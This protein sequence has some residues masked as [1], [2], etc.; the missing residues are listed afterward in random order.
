M[1]LISDV[2]VF[3]GCG[4][5]DLPTPQ[6]VAASWHFIKALCG[7]T[8]PGAV[9]PFGKLS[10]CCYSAGYSAGYGHHRINCGGPIR[11]LW[12]GDRFIGI[13]HMHQSGIGAL[14]FY[15]NYAL[16]I[17]FCGTLTAETAVRG[18]RSESAEPGYY[19]VTSSDGIRSEVTVSPRCARHRYTFPASGGR[20]AIDFTNDG[21]YEGENVASRPKSWRVERLSASEAAAEAVL[22]GVCVSFYVSCRGSTGCTLWRGSAL[23]DTDRL[24]ACGAAAEERGGCCFDLAEQTAELVVSV[25]LRGERQAREAAEAETASFET[26]R[27]EAHRAWAE[28]LSR[29]EIETADDREREIFASNFYHSLVKPSDWQD[30]SFLYRQEDFM[31]DFCTLWDQYKTQL[32]LIFTLFDDI[33]GKIVSTYEALSETLGF[34]P[35]TFVLCDQFRI[36]AKQAQMLGVYVLYDAFCRGIG[37]PESLLAAIRRD[38]TRPEYRPFFETGVCEKTT[39]TLDMAEGCLA[40]AEL[41]RACGDTALANHL[42]SSA[43]SVWQAFDP[44][45]GLLRA[46]ADYYEGNHWNYSFRPMR[47]MR[48][49]IALTGSAEAFVRLCDRFFGFTDAADTTARFEGFNNE[50]DM[51]APYAYLYAGRHDRLCDV[52]AD[53]LNSMFT[54]G[55]GGLPGNNDSGGLSSCYLWNALGVF[56]VSGQN[57]MLI[58]TPRF[59]QAVL[60][61]SGGRDFQI[62]RRGRGRYVREAKLNGVPIQNFQ[63]SVR[64]MMSGGTL[65]LTMSEQPVC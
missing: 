20:I 40:A 56:P 26:V 48:K 19:A 30:E 36:E 1:H 57:K 51:E 59:E 18:I 24:S 35:H 47:D 11:P 15:E 58:G 29:I 39:H 28:R 49:R 2:N 14:G 41:A 3:Q 23:T 61:L 7:N 10:A 45:T 63:F 52:L 44:A 38:L 12:D 8:H 25:S 17:P 5:I 50:T 9:R 16:T 27:E 60:H 32:P 64:Q 65:E 21:L 4:A 53:G 13:S 42:E 22:Q 46:D 54:T 6:G 62:V 34:L 55:R 43:Q 37:D 33:S 31:L